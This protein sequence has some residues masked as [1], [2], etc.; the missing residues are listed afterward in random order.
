MDV[1]AQED[2][3]ENFLAGESK[4]FNDDLILS[5]VDEDIE[6]KREN[7]LELENNVLGDCDLSN[8]DNVKDEKN[9]I[10][11]KRYRRNSLVNALKK[12]SIRCLNKM[13]VMEDVREGSD[14]PG[15]Q[16]SSPGH[17]EQ[18]PN[19]QEIPQVANENSVETEETSNQ[20]NGETKETTE[21]TKSEDKPENKVKE[22]SEVASIPEDASNDS[23]NEESA[24]RKFESEEESSHKRLRSTI[25]QNYVLREKIFGEYVDNAGCTTVAQIQMQMDQIVSEIRTLNDLAREKEKE[26]NNIIHLKK[27]KEELLLRVQRR[28]QVMMLSNDKIDWNDVDSSESQLDLDKNS[29]N[30]V[31]YSSS[32]TKIPSDS[33]SKQKSKNLPSTVIEINGHSGDLRQNKQ[34]PV[35]DVQSIIADYRQRHPEAVPRRGRR[36]RSLY[37]QGDSSMVRSGNGSVMSFS[38]ISLGS[39]SQVKQNLSASSVEANTEL[40]LLLTA[41]DNGKSSGTKS[42]T[43]S[44]QLESASFKDVL[45]QFAKLSQTERQDLLQTAM[46]PPPY[47][48]VT[49]HPVPAHTQTT[50]NSLLHGILTK[51]Q[52]RSENNKSTFSPTLARL[53][54]APERAAISPHSNHN[55][56]VSISDMLSNN[57]ARNEITITPVGGQ[58]DLPVKEK[59]GDEEE[60]EDGADRLVIDESEALDG[61]KCADNGSDAGDEVPQ[62]QG[63][64]QK[65][66]QFVCAGCGNQWYCSRECQVVAWDEHSEVCSG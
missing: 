66:A 9:I 19:I 39:G 37:N 45:M 51:T 46:K 2:A 63:C 23:T 17:A 44:S 40:G 47:S 8:G 13:H 27:M 57:K 32:G 38:S 55:T 60:V 36:I 56:P 58:F 35:L 7:V 49:V 64:N 18:R 50:S 61:R 5:N 16:P 29:K 1:F 10:D 54:T 3:V 28:K 65:P 43:D 11:Y 12:R 59:Q 52:S 30:L 21:E 34:R 33:S 24:K 26:W 6:F 25:D 62:C 31:I 20:T 53:L 22:E 15:A 48:E 41:V 14:V 42:L 4:E